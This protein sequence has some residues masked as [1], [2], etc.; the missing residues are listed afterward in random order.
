MAG[1]VW[2]TACGDADPD[3]TGPTPVP[4]RPPQAAGTIPEQML[5]AVSSGQRNGPGEDLT[6]F[7]PVEGLSRAAIELPGDGI[8]VGL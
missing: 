3:V 4:N 7:Q 6:W 8:E 5:S 1:V 2:A